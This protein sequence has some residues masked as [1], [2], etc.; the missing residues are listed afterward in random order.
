MG[1]ARGNRRGKTHHS[2][3]C[4]SNLDHRVCC[5]QLVVLDDSA[6]VAASKWRVVDSVDT[7]ERDSFVR[8][9]TNREVGLSV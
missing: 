4:D 9:N 5:D 2:T 7:S 8:D 3:D 6:L 1:V